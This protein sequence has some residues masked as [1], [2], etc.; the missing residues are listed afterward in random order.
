MTKNDTLYFSHG[1]QKCPNLSDGIPGL[2]FSS[3]IADVFWDPAQKFQSR[4]VW[5]FRDRGLRI[6]RIAEQSHPKATSIFL[7]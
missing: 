4:F 1:I 7:V 2:K 5:G 6:S 3:G